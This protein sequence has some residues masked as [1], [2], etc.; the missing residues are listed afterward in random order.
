MGRLLTLGAGGW[1]A[2]ERLQIAVVARSLVRR[3]RWRGSVIGRVC[4]SDCGV[5][6][7]ED[8]RSRCRS[9]ESSRPGP[10]SRAAPARSRRATGSSV[11]GLHE[12]DVLG[13]DVERAHRLACRC[14]QRIGR[15]L[16]VCDGRSG[17]CKR[18]GHGQ[19]LSALLAAQVCIAAGH[20]EPVGFAHSRASLDAHGHVQV[21][22]HASDHDRLLGVLLAEVGDV[23]RDDVQELRNDGR[24]AAEVAAPRTAPS[25]RS[26]RPSTSTE[27]EK[28]ARVDLLGGGRKQQVRSSTLG[29]L[30]VALLLARDSGRGRRAR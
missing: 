12:R 14:H 7:P 20:R 15:A 13:L 6:V 4:G 17:G 23:G 2:V 19:R 9:A 27:V 16:A 1:T 10:R 5:A 18:A 29:Q 26:V 11:S 8:P 22:D 25:R 24:D 28:P 30:A 21:L 3:V